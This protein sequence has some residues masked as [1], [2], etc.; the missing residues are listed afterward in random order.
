MSQNQARKANKSDIIV[1]KKRENQMD[2][3]RGVSKKKWYEDK[4]RRMEKQLAANGLDL[5]ASYMLD[6]QEDAEA[7]YKKW[8][9]KDTPFGW[10][11]Q[12]FENATRHL[13]FGPVSH[14]C[15]P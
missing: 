12:L 3:P 7:K 4:K 10:D 11:G 1:E 6:T 2:E 5:S 13:C 14:T 8:E 9:K 15:L